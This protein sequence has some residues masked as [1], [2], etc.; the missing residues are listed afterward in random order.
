V[1]FFRCLVQLF[2]HSRHT[3]VTTYA[4]RAAVMN[5]CQMPFP[6]SSL[7]VQ[8]VAGIFRNAATTLFVGVKC[9][10]WLLVILRACLADVHISRMGIP[11][12]AMLV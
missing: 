10:W 1:F 3:D 7:S 5:L 11:T 8:S 2:Y 4:N 9:P 12:K 6:P